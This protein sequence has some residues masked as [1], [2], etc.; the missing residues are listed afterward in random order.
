L[1]SMQYIAQIGMSFVQTNT[2]FSNNEHQYYLTNGYI[3]LNVW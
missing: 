3:L 1:T 2:M